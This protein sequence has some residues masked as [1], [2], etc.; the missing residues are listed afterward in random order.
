V[1]LA[2]TLGDRRTYIGGS[3]IGTIMGVNPW[4]SPRE[5][6]LKKVSPL[7]LEED[8]PNEYMQ[9]GIYLEETC[10]QWYMDRTGRI[11]HKVNSQFTHPDYPFLVGHIDRRILDNGDGFGTG[12][13]ECKTTGT[14]TDW[15]ELE[16]PLGYYYQLQFYLALTGYQW[17][18]FAILKGGQQFLVHRCDRNQSHIDALIEAAVDFWNAYVVPRV[19]PPATCNR[20]LSAASVPVVIEASGETYRAVQEINRC[21]VREKALADHRAALEFRVKVA[22]GHADTLAYHTTPIATYKTNKAGNRTFRLKT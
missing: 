10:A 12:C 6:Y 21:K 13:L 3:E 1:T 17:G 20:D 4:Q 18:A 16:V 22:M 2:N 8:E 9:A 14:F 19:E 7:P 11:V 5:L 15:G